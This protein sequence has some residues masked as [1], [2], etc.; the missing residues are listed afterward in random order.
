[1]MIFLIDTAVR[2]SRSRH[3]MITM[4]P[5]PA[6]RTEPAAFA[7]TEEMGG[8]ANMLLLFYWIRE[9]G[10]TG[11]RLCRTEFTT[12]ERDGRVAGD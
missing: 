10:A 4:A 5:A 2:A 3:M 11:R 8:S 12:A 9:S 1:M 6:A 7:K